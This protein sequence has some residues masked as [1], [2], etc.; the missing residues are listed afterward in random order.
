VTGFG[1]SAFFAAGAVARRCHDQ[2]VVVHRGARDLAGV[3]SLDEDVV[4][5]L[6]A[7]NDLL[8][9]VVAERPAETRAA[10]FAVPRGF[11]TAKDEA[12]E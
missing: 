5:K 12:D 3:C 10:G 7:A 2:G 8:Q 9:A 11:A 1:V 6:N 4:P